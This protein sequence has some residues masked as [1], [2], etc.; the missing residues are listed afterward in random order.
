MTTRKAPRTHGSSGT[1]FRLLLPAAISIAIMSPGLA[2]RPVPA[3]NRTSQIQGRIDESKRASL[4]DTMNPLLKNATDIGRVAD[5]TQFDN[6]LVVLKRAPADQ[7]AMTALETRQH[8][9]SSPDFQ[10]WL[11]P[12]QV[13]KL[14]GPKAADLAGLK[15]WLAGHGLQVNGMSASGM[16]VDI[17]GSAG[18][19]RAAFGADVRR[20]RLGSETRVAN[21][22]RLSVP[23]ALAGLVAGIA[24][25]DDFRLSPMVSFPRQGPVS[26]SVDNYAG[27]D[28]VGPQDF[29]TIYDLRRVWDAGVLGAGQTIAVVERSE[30]VPSD[31]AAFDR[32]FA[33]QPMPAVKTIRHNSATCRDP[34]QAL[35]GDQIEATLDVEWSGAIAPAATVVVAA[36]ASTAS[37][38][39][40]DLAAQQAVDLDPDV[41]SVSFGTCEKDEPPSEQA[42]YNNLWEQASVQG[43]SVAVAAGDSGAEGCTTNILNASNGASVNALASTPFNTAVGGT[44]FQDR[45][46]ANQGPTTRDQ[47]YWSNHNGR[48]GLSARSYVP[49][50]TW[51]DSCAIPFVLSF[52]VPGTII[53]PG[54]KFQVAV[55]CGSLLSEFTLLL[56]GGG[57]GFSTLYQQP[58]WQI[59]LYGMPPVAARQLPDISLFAADGLYGH[60]LLFCAQSV[61]GPCSW[62]AGTHDVAGGTSFAAPA[63]AGVVALINQYKNQRQGD[64]NYR[65]YQLGLQQ[66]GAR[67]GAPAGQLASCDASLGNKVSSS[68]LFHTVTT[69]NIRQGCWT[70]RGY[71]NDVHLDDAVECYYGGINFAVYNNR[72]TGALANGMMSFSN[73]K[74]KFDP[75]YFDAALGFSVATGLGSPD[76]GNIVSAW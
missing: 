26:Q 51:N 46:Q 11:T 12:A 17:S 57:G 52:L 73:N 76:I 53:P 29:A 59:P 38:D 1:S 16:S 71:Y 2:Q 44:D 36:C 47:E 23:S 7:A 19:L 8:T 49:E 25:L 56:G 14:F 50:M 32:H 6:V 70:E 72:P 5:S 27:L 65:L 66:F 31:V 28:L 22:A 54:K 40:V 9:K 35:N 42:F 3:F 39:G 20:L 41:V 10:H 45:V 67:G 13:G 37:T 33:V 24:R 55:E 64:V 58:N 75:G 48:G 15:E 69:G 62:D 61:L 60:A 43:T 4:A 18:A 68:C 30:V 34:G 63:F 74:L 21:V